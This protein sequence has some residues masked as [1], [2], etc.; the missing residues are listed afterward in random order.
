[1]FIDSHDD[2]NTSNISDSEGRDNN[3]SESKE[4]EEEEENSANKTQNY[5]ENYSKDLVITIKIYSIL[6]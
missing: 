4:G 1:M 6:L 2:K 3:Q 5:D